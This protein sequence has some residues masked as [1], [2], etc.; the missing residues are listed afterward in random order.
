M[1]TEVIMCRNLWGSEI[2]QKS[3]T[4]FFCAS[5]LVS[6]GNKW[7]V[8]NGKSLFNFSMWLKSENTQAF[9]NALE[10]E[11]GNVIIKGKANNSPSWVHP[12]LFIDLAL[13][14]SPELKIEAYK[15]L[16][17]S[18][19]KYRNQSGDSYKKM[20][21]A[22]YITASN[23]SLYQNEIQ[24]VAKKIKE[25][26]AVSDWQQASES[27]LKLRDKIHEYISLFSDIV[28]NR[29]ALVSVAIQKARESMA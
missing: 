17:D 19:I 27:Q 13:A 24:E 6:A 18:L 12:F 23:K 21:G 15:W 20:C 2:R 16:Y 25:A 3:K 4:E 5:D 8:S 28:N 10:K 1:E 14:M 7:R 9:I 22:L 11:Y 26:C 29:E